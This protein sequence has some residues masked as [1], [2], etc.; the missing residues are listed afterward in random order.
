MFRSRQG[1]WI[2]VRDSREMRSGMRELARSGSRTW[3]W[4]RLF[5]V[6][7]DDDPTPVEMFVPR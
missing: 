3:T 5:P 4:R 7:T 2:E 1:S 6:Y